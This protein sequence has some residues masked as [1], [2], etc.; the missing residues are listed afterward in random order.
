LSKQ[1][2]GIVSQYINR[3]FSRPIAI[4]LARKTNV[5]P[6]Q[7]TL[8][9]FL[10]CIFSG[11][12]FTFKMS[13]IGGVL[14]QVAS[15]MDGVDGDLAVITGRASPTGGFLDSLLDRYGDVAIVI[16]LILNTLPYVGSAPEFLL[17]SMMAIFGS[18]M[19]SYSRSRAEGIKIIFRKGISGYA[20]NRDIRLFLIMI[21]GILNQPYITLI[22]LAAL[23]NLVVLVRILE[24][25]V[26]T[27]N[28]MDFGNCRPTDE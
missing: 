4:L 13:L 10:I 18:L 6:N 3:K 22:I 9:S 5:T 1:W 24:V 17:I 8:L 21:G 14:A 2:D 26:K 19:V 11:A 25:M 20:A 12:A 28:K 7:M 15:I 23:T 16:G 27:R